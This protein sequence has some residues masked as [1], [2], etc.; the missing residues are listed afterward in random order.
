MTRSVLT[1]AVILAMLA[2][3][4]AGAPALG[5]PAPALVVP[6]IDGAGFDLGVL[7]GKVVIVNFW[8]T[9]CPPC[10]K[11]M[12]ALDAFF[13]RFHARG[14]EMVGTSVDR[15]RDRKAVL[16]AARAVR[17]PVALLADAVANG[18]GKPAV[19][20]VT[21]VVDR[22]GVVRAVL[23]PDAGAVTESSLEQTVAPLLSGGHPGL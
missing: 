20:P 12:Q 5:E 11:E 17:Y 19:L 9:W 15:K 16:K 1:S 4:A 2:G 13:A 18:F 21:Y 23:T 6:L 22:A 7:R 10:R 3:P 14:V 8:A